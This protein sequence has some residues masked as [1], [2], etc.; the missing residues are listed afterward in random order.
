[1]HMVVSVTPSAPTSIVTRI[2]VPAAMARPSWLLVVLV[3]WI[4]VYLVGTTLIALVPGWCKRLT[5]E[6]DAL[7][8][9]YISILYYVRIEHCC[10]HDSDIQWSGTIKACHSVHRNSRHQNCYSY[11]NPFIFFH[12]SCASYCVHGGVLIS[13][14][15]VDGPVFCILLPNAGQHLTCVISPNLAPMFLVR[16][17]ENTKMVSM[18]NS[19]LH[20]TYSVTLFPAATA[21]L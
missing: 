19:L 18:T 16:S 2:I 17:A 8:A 4:T 13:E 10:T 20:L 1:L 14:A 9:A 7:I 5:R 15:A 6:D 12:R 11:A 3:C 21:V